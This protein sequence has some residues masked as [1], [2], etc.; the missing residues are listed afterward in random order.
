MR[1][2]P[3]LLAPTPR[4]SP[5]P[6]RPRERA[7]R[8]RPVRETRRC[9]PA[10]ADPDEAP[11]TGRSSSPWAPFCEGKRR[12]VPDPSSARTPAKISSPPPKQRHQAAPEKR[13]GGQAQWEPDRGSREKH[14]E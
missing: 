2:P 3:P 13:R 7:G 14:R 10:A 4:E 6:P 5:L 8:D 9:I 11:D 12:R 1:T